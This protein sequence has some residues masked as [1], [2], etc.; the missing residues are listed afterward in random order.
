M[1]TYLLELRTEEI[2]ANALPS[3]RAQLES[4]FGERLAAQGL[5]GWT[6]RALSTN[7][8]LA[9]LI[10]DLPLRQA[11]RSERV[12]GP[13]ARVAFGDDGSPTKAAEGFARKLG[14]DIAALERETT[15]KGDYV[16]ATVTHSGRETSAL[17]AEITPEVVRGLRFPKI[18]RWGRGDHLFVRP[19]HGVVALFDD[20]IV[21]LELF[22][23]AAGRTTVGHRVHSPEAFDLAIAADYESALEARGVLVDPARRRAIL[24]ETADRLAAEVSC[25]VHP[26]DGLVSEHVELVE[27]PGLLRGGVEKRFLELPREVVITTLRHHQKCLVLTTATGELAPHFLTVVDRTD[28]PEGLIQQGNEWVIGARLADAGFFFAED[29]KHQLA[30]LVPKLERIEWHRVMGSLGAKAE[31]VGYLAGILADRTNAG[32]NEDETTNAARLAKADLATNMVGEFPELQGVMGG[33]YLRL[34]GKGEELWTAVRDHYSPVGFDGT[35]PASPLGR[36]IGAADRLDTLAALFAAGER[37]TGSKDPFGLRRAGQGLV[38]IFA[39][40]GWEAPLEPVINRAAH[41]VCQLS[42]SSESD[43]TATVTEFLADRVRRYLV[44]V[45]GVA[46]DTADAVMAADSGNLPSLVERARALETVRGSETFRALSLAFKRV[47][48]ITE[49]Q[50][51]AQVDPDLFELDAERD[52]HAAATTFSGRLAGLVADRQIDEAFAA[53]EPLAAALD[54]FFVDVLVMAE[55][56]RIRTNRIAMLQGLGRDFLTLADLSKLQ[57]EGGD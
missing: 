21:D 56:P 57:I 11:D 44:E 12:L 15:D 17:L 36:L 3:A 5:T 52:L 9:L 14:L 49:N 50:A 18:M 27:Y 26:D 37:P 46:G 7:R 20:A 53:M 28:D 13:P 6:L 41:E 19:V 35:L 38:K 24:V 33:H 42:E 1:A 25:T 47:R 54:R 31:R 30:D 10:D 39:E 34:E 48:N 16:A 23:I 40:S 51:A 8:R 45:V 43:V 55:D 4:G 22:G 32:T 2:P 29:R